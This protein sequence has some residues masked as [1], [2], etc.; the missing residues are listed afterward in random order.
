MK[1]EAQLAMAAAG[2]YFLGRSRKARWALLLGGVAASRALG[3]PGELVQQGTKA[4]KS[5]P[6]L[7][8]LGGD[9][10]GRLLAAGRS[11]AVRAASG[12]IESL[13]DRLNER[14]ESLRQPDEPSED[15]SRDEADSPDEPEQPE[16]P[17][18]PAAVGSQD[19]ASSGRRGGGARTATREKSGS[20]ARR[21]ETRQS[22]PRKPRQTTS[23]RQGSSGGSKSGSS[24]SSGRSRS[25]SGT[26]SSSRSGS[27]AR[28]NESDG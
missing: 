8:K 26:R 3:G 19:K 24:G 1:R 23:Q 18:E 12:Q 2:G 27:R 6:D 22:T 20:G 10:S 9:V 16:E 7:S 21:D 14:A 4:L 13:T 11:A 15:E 17:E 25:S 28:R 5:S